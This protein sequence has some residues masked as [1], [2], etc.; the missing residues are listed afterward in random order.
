MPR[1]EHARQR[2]GRIET[3]CVS[4]S[5]NTRVIDRERDKSLRR[6]EKVSH[7][8]ARQIFTYARRRMLFGG[9]GG[10]H[11]AEDSSAMLA[12]PGQTARPG[13]MTPPNVWVQNRN[14]NERIPVSLQ[15][16]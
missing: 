14:R 16:A 11:E 6:E 8:F 7:E 13:D 2:S 1:R 15:E 4:S 10:R 9:E 5:E 12:A 3:R